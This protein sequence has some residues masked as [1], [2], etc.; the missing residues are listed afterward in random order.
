VATVRRLAFGPQVC[1]RADDGSA[2]EWL[3][4]DGLGGYAT[5]TVSGLRT[6]RYHGL[7]VV[8]G[9][10]PSR[11]R[12]GLAS[13]DAVLTLP[14]GASVRLGVHE[15]ADRTIAPRGHELLAG[16]ELVDGPPPLALADRRRG[17]GT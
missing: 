6:R 2:R 13:L 7:L 9:D 12:L 5:G 10:T 11:R 4:A 17:A 1:G 3:L 16:F 14:T 15:W 8:A